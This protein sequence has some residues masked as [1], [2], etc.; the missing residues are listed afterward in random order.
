MRGYL[1]DK[2]FLIGQVCCAALLAVLTGSFASA[3]DS[4]N[5]AVE[6]TSEKMIALFCANDGKLAHCAGQDTSDCKK[7][8]KPFVD[9]CLGE[10][11]ARKLRVD[12]DQF[13]RCFWSGF[14][15]KYGQSFKY[16]DECFYSDNKDGN[17][18]QETPPELEKGMTLLNP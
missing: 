11:Q 12:G 14:S 2:L 9:N 3:E 8:V 16:S 4:A 15:R 6:E 5:R 10:V 17:P 13:E 7:I 1:K 18:L